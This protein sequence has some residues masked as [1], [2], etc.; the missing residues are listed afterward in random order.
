MGIIELDTANMTANNCKHTYM[1]KQFSYLFQQKI[2][3][4]Q[5]RVKLT[6][7]ESNGTWMQQSKMRCGFCGV[8]LDIVTAYPVN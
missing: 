1:V 2:M 3:N 5:V 6:M 4:K 8:Q 7:V